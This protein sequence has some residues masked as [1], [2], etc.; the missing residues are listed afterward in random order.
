[1]LPLVWLPL[2][3][4]KSNFIHEK[5]FNSFKTYSTNFD[6]L[7][8]VINKNSSIIKNT[9]IV[10]IPGPD[11]ISLFSGFPKFPII[12]TIISPL[13]KK[14]PNLISA[15]NPARFTIFG[16]EL[17]IFRD[18]LNKKL[19]KNSIVKC[20]DMTK[21]TESYIHTILCQGNLSPLDL[22]ATSRI[23][24]LNHSMF[25]MPLPDFLILADVVME[26]SEKSSDTYI[27]NPGNFTKDFSFSII[28][29]IK[30][31]VDSCKI[32]L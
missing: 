17:V 24:N 26:F 19:S 13:K 2:V 25:I 4:V 22:N 11:D 3:K 23:W 30:N 8:N 20:T 6:S 12:D 21:N 15:T 31:E 9:L 5:S 10:L 1:M 14:I 29:P 18:N 28:Y 16:K 7:A 32:N 27:I